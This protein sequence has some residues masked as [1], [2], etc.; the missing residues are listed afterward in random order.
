[1]ISAGCGGQTNAMNITGTGSGITDEKQRSSS[2]AESH[3]IHS[4]FHFLMRLIT[5]ALIRDQKV[6]NKA[7]LIAI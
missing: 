7:R 2:E 6:T 5:N 4:N 1:V 3:F